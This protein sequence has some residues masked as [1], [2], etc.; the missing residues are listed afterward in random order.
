MARLIRT[1]PWTHDLGHELI[2]GS[3]PHG[4]MSPLAPGVDENST[5]AGRRVTA[6]ARAEE[7]RR[8]SRLLHDDIG[9]SLTAL[10]VKLAILRSR[11]GASM[12]G[13]IGSAQAILEKTLNQLQRL[14][15]DLHPSAVEDFGLVPALRSHIKSF[16]QKSALAI[17][18][19][20]DD[21]VDQADV[22]LSLAVFR[23][24]QA[25]LMDL[26]GS[27]AA[28][29]VLSLDVSPGALLLRAEAR[30]P[31]RAFKGKEALP[32][33]AAFHEEVLTAGGT[34]TFRSHRNQAHICAR[35]PMTNQGN[36]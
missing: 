18:F 6:R 13:E 31:A 25:L 20:A 35:F 23:S 4:D 15:Q 14:S 2:P 34:V 7:R 24:I 11:A 12:R 30:I 3:M 27:L 10:N 21:L 1:A 36:F 8:I 29:A 33:I 26:E 5:A 28:R 22:E 17:H 16:S 32:Q 9:Q 19:R